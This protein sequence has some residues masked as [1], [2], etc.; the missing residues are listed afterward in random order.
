M[1]YADLGKLFERHLA[2][3]LE[4]TRLLRELDAATNFDRPQG[5][6]TLDLTSEIRA[7]LTELY[8]Q[9]VHADLILQIVPSLADTTI[10]PTTTAIRDPLPIRS[11]QTDN[12]D[13]LPTFTLGATISP[14]S[15]IE[16][17]GDQSIQ[18]SQTLLGETIDLGDAWVASDDLLQRQILLRELGESSQDH[19]DHV[20]D[21]V[22][23]AQIAGQLEHPNILPVYSLAWSP[24]RSPYYTMKFV[25]GKSFHQH[26][27]AFHK[28]RPVL[29]RETLRESLEMLLAVCNAISYAHSR[30]V[31]HGQLSSTAISLGQFG[32]VM[33]INWSHAILD[34]EDQDC[35]KLVQADLRAIASLLDE[36]LSGTTADHTPT[37]VFAANI[38]RPLTS[39]LRE[40]CST[41]SNY[42]SVADF[43]DEIRA[44]E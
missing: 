33:V 7:I 25:D 3:P 40:A 16:R 34:V 18:Y 12:A 26:I 30:G 20:N 10:D 13:S 19:T 11:N 1:N 36:L 31:Y 24:E 22:R 28:N 27:Q 35:T 9:N 17:L 29:N 14:P 4:E 8:F 2:S 23:E 6:E 43:A 38:P 41:T 21:F 37:A 39:L 5:D 42:S 32:E 15:T 44:V